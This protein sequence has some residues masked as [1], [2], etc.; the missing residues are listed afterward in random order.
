MQRGPFNLPHGLTTEHAIEFTIIAC[1][2]SQGLYLVGVEQLTDTG[3]IVHR[4]VL[5]RGETIVEHRIR[6]VQIAV[7]EFC[8]TDLIVEHLKAALPLLVAQEPVVET[9]TVI[10]QVIGR[11]DGQQQEDKQYDSNRLVGL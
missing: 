11:N 10:E 1:H 7:F 8:L 6:D 9:M 2:L 3:G 4:F 5:Q